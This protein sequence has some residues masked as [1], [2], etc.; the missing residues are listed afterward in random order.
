MRQFS[1]MVFNILPIQSFES[2]R[3]LAMQLNT[4]CGSQSVVNSGA[5]EGMSEAV[6][7]L[8]QRFCDSAAGRFAEQLMEQISRNSHDSFAQTSLE[9]VADRSRG[10]EQRV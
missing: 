7:P 5:D 6:A 9:L 1:K 2:D 4:F 8:P 3:N 10:L